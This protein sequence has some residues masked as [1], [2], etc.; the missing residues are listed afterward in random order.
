MY[1]F[2]PSDR[3]NMTYKI[4]TFREENNFFWLEQLEQMLFTVE[5]MGGWSSGF[6]ISCLRGLASPQTLLSVFLG[7]S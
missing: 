3:L 4:E 2:F 6:H 5:I 1:S 7:I